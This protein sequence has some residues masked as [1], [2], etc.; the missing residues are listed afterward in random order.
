[1]AIPLEVEDLYDDDDRKIHETGRMEIISVHDE[2]YECGECGS[3]DIDEEE[4]N[5]SNE[6]I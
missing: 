2:H 5:D 3:L 4:E 6:Y 1:V